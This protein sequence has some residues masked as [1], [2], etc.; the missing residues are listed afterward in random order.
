[1]PAKRYTS[2]LAASLFGM[3]AG[4]VAEFVC[5]YQITQ[6][7]GGLLP[8]EEFTDAKFE[9]RLW[10]AQVAELFPIIMRETRVFREKHRREIDNA[11]EYIE[12]VRGCQY[13][14]F[15]EGLQNTYGEPINSIDELELATLR[16]L[17][18][19]KRQDK[20][21]NVTNEYV[22]Y[23]PDDG[24]RNELETLY[25]MRNKIAHGKICT[26]AEVEWLLCGVDNVG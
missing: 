19:K 11:F 3:D 2:T 6:D 10:N 24:M 13:N 26:P 22:L 12:S 15:G 1:M 7:P 18:H 25:E 9:R 14:I 23:I 17:M 16:Y 5:D 21:G 4:R 8:A 20:I